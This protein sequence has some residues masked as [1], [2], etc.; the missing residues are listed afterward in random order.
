MERDKETEGCNNTGP[1]HPHPPAP[2]DGHRKASRSCAHRQIT[3]SHIKP[4][5]VL[6]SDSLKL[7]L[8]Q[9]F[10]VSKPAGDNYEEMRR[11]H[12]L[13]S[14]NGI[15]NAAPCLLPH[16]VIPAFTFQLPY[17]NTPPPPPPQHTHTHTHT[18]FSYP[19]KYI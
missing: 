10:S 15:H 7:S 4:E 1:T 13:C 17:P 2:T 16:N 19:D 9:S 6:N 18:P 8:T 12:A 11:Q 5:I 3:L 14:N